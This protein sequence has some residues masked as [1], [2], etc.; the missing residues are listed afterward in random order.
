MN[1]GALVIFPT[2]TVYALGCLMTNKAGIEKICRI[3]GKKE[4]QARMS[5]PQYQC[6]LTIYSTD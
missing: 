1:K 6:H 2:D 4:K 3:T 5:L